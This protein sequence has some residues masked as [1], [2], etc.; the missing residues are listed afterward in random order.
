MSTKLVIIWS[1]FHFWLETTKLWNVLK[2]NFWLETAKLWNVLK[3]NFWLKTT[4]LSKQFYLKKNLWWCPHVGNNCK[5]KSKSMSMNFYSYF[6]C[7]TT[8]KSLFS[9]FCCNKILIFS[10]CILLF[11]IWNQRSFNIKVLFKGQ[12]QWF[13]KIDFKIK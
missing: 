4:K 3:T 12:I 9:F 1:R 13:P 8:D 5:S 7:V 11:D 10:L 6:C 2:T